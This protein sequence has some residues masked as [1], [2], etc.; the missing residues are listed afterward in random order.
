M[1]VLQVIPELNAGGVEQ[2]ILDLTEA[3]TAAGHT[4][5]IVSAG[6]RLEDK[7]IAAGG[8][9]HRRNIGSKN[10]LSLPS[11][12]AATK[13]IIQQNEIDIVHAHSRAPAWPSY[14]ASRKTKT[15]FVTTYHGIYNANNAI[16][17]GYNAIMTRSD[18]V[19]AN[20]NYTRDHII[21][22]HGISPDKIAVLPR[23]VDM[24]VFD[25]AN[26]SASDIFALRSEWGVGE[27]QICL[28]LPGRLTRWKGQHVAI[29]A[30]AA[31]PDNCRLILLGDAQG[32]TDYETELTSLARDLGIESRV[33]LPG[34]FTNMPLA[35]AASD[36][37]ISAST[38]P[39]A[40]GLIA[41]EAQ[42]MM[43]PV[44]ASAHGGSLE[45]VD[46]G[47]TGRLTA[48]GDAADLAAGITTALAGLPDVGA[49]GRA[50][51][52]R[53]FSKAALQAGVL[54]VYKNCLSGRF[55]RVKA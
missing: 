36:V 35:L 2:T 26:V 24:D 43:K 5:H 31:L 11:N 22:E 16:K 50:R 19:I 49:I 52:A 25:P 30:L 34:H 32:R 1:N 55:P 42:A 48:V 10:I 29:K 44:V 53:S 13:A 15:P 51:I 40:F 8:I 46:D 12:I 45:T 7:V 4:A 3:L 23:G 27:G 14:Y 37:V 20:S 38:D 39:E 17:R 47:R 33:K 41:A 21:K 28:L 18:V 54:D 6:G 9:L